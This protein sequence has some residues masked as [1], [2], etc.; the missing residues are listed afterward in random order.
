MSLDQVL[1][2]FK[3]LHLCKINEYVESGMF[4]A[5]ET[6]LILRFLQGFSTSVPL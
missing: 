3:I 6:N 1:K 5:L 4:V 2:H